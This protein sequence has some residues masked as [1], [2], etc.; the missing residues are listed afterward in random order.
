MRFNIDGRVGRAGP[1]RR[2]L[3][4]ALIAGGLAAGAQETR[5]AQRL[6][7]ERLYLDLGSAATGA[8]LTSV[9]PRLGLEL[10]LDSSWKLGLESDIYY[11]APPA[12]DT[13]VFQADLLGLLRWRAR[14]DRGLSLAAGAGPLFFNSSLPGGRLFGSGISRAEALL[15]LEAAWTWRLF[16]STLYLEPALRGNLA[17]GF[18]QRALVVYPGAELA[19]RLGWRLAR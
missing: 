17:A 12:A 13:A 16:G 9:H 15:S 11:S 8:V 14:A 18:A 2:L 6:A 1:A 3:V 5:G 7:L 4:A 19:L 10:G